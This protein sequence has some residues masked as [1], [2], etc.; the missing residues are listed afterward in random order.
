M[1]LGL[2]GVERE[3]PLD[4]PAGHERERGR[5]SVAPGEGLRAPR[6]EPR[7]GLDVRADRVRTGGG[8]AAERARGLRGV[9]DIDPERVEVAVDDAGRRHRDHAAPVGVERADPGHP[10]AAGVD[11]D[12]AGGL[13][14]R[15][16]VAAEDLVVEL[17]EQ[18]VDPGQSAERLHGVLVLRLGARALG[19]VAHDTQDRP[20]GV[21]R[22][23]H[24]VDRELG[25]VLAPA[26]QRE[27][28]AHRAR[29][30]GREVPGPMG[31]V[32]RESLGDQELDRLSDQLAREVAEHDLGL[33]VRV[34]DQRVRA[35]DE[36]AVRHELED[37]LIEVH[38]AMS[39]A[40]G[41]ARR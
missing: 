36:E 1:G 16:R 30:R 33:G 32:V 9:R 21:D 13:H 10:E 41:E 39:V 17:A 27:P 2:G 19:D 29:A 37:P 14:R 7:I 22:A 8:A 3:E 24:D 23:Q 12:P 35:D 20:I 28:G 5:R 25:A 15:V 40:F 26:V 34:R 6:G 4:L 38:G 18:R 11:R 31:D